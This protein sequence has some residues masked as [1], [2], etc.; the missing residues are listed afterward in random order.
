MEGASYAVGIALG[1]NN[2]VPVTVPD[3]AVWSDASVG[4]YERLNVDRA[5]EDHGRK[6]HG[7]C[8]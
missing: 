5:Q 2:V 8:L 4:N 6:Q 3:A 1:T 7:H